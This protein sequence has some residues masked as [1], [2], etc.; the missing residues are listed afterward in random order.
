MASNGHGDGVD[1]QQRR[2]LH[3]GARPRGMQDDRTAPSR[4]RAEWFGGYVIE[5]QVIPGE[6]ERLASAFSDEIVTRIDFI[7]ASEGGLELSSYRVGGGFGPVR[8]NA[9]ISSGGGE[10]RFAEGQIRR[11]AVDTR[12]K[13]LARGASI[14]SSTRKVIV[15]IHPHRAGFEIDVTVSYR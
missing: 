10:P 5:T 8:L 6:V 14:D 4:Q 11:M 7:A 3:Y 2:R 9:S 13:V 1:V 12:A 15:T